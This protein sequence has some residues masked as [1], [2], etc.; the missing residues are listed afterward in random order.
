MPVYPGA[1]KLLFGASCMR[2]EAGETQFN[3]GGDF[4]GM[5]AAHALAHADAAV[6]LVDR[7][8]YHTFE[9]LLYQA[10]AGYRPRGGGRRVPTSPI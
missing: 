6:A 10:S 4:V 8:N 3:S 5:N 7:H 9:P 1:P 2:D